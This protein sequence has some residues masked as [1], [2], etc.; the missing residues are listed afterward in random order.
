MEQEL[1]NQVVHTDYGQFDLTWVDGGGF[2][3]D[4][5]RFFAGQVNG[6]AGAADP[7]GVYFNLARRSGGSPVRIVALDGPPAGDGPPW[8]DV[9]EVSLQ[10]PVGSQVSWWTW[11][12]GSGGPLP[13]VAPGS[14]RLR[15]SSKGRDEGHAGEFSSEMVDAYLI[16]VW[17]APPGPDA[18]LSS[19][20]D[21]AKYW[22]R[23]VGSRRPTV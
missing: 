21:D 19:V 23:E 10:I 14:Y 13:P 3:G 22:H 15:F 18:I 1:L 17:P 7:G 6:L 20:S 12:G 9:V 11:A 5:D 4:V 16:Q 2:D 8:A